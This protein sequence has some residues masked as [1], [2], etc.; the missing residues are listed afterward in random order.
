MRNQYWTGSLEEA[1]QNCSSSR[2]RFS[3]YFGWMPR[4]GLTRRSSLTG[5]FMAKIWYWR[6]TRFWCK[7]ELG[8]EPVNRMA[9]RMRDGV[10]TW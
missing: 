10:L 7:R 6:C 5:F 9:I 2:R 4:R 3:H 1:G 8:A